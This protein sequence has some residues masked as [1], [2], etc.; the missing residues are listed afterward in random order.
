MFSFMRKISRPGLVFAALGIFLLYMSV[1]DT[2]TSFKSPKSFEDVLNG[3]AAAGDRV[4][5]RVPFLLDAFASEQTW[6]EN[7][8]NNSVTPKKTSHYYYVLPFGDTYMG[9]TVNKDLASEAKLLTDQTYGYLSG[10]AYPSANL[11]TDTRIAKMTGELREMFEDEL[12][13]YYGFTDSG[14]SQ[15]TLLMAEPRAFTTI[16]VFCVVGV[17]LLLLGI[18]LLIRRFRKF[19]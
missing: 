11:V 1:G 17:G 16:R 15:M 5:G 4:K 18:L 3:D 12:K 13:E 7:R 14:I 8:S 10:G 2:I 6:T 9:L 19:S